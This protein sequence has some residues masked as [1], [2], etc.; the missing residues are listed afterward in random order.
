[1]SRTTRA[2]ADGPSERL[3][4]A[5]QAH[6]SDVLA[7]LQRRVRPTEDAAD[8]L[9]EVFVIAWRKVD[10]LPAADEPLRMWLFVTA[11]NVLANHVR[12]TRRADD[13]AAAL[14]TQLA[15]QLR[16]QP[17][18]ASPSSSSVSVEEALDALPDA[19]RELVRLVHWEGFSIAEA[20]QMTDVTASTARSRYAAARATLAARLKPARPPVV[21][22]VG[23]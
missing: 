20:A 5:V 7:Y 4:A 13:L 11:R 1:M 22:A 21:V 3:T 15:E 17:A 23:P 2:V 10:H 18:A 8:L 6:G 14:R 19:Q 16:T 12:G 9:S